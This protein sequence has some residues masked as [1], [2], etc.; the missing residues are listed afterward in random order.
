MNITDKLKSRLRQFASAEKAAFLP[1]FF[2]TAP[3]QYGHG[4]VFIGVMVPA[5]RQVAREFCD[6]AVDIQAL[7]DSPIHEERLVA[8]L[9]VMHRY[10]RAAKAGDMGEMRKWF[11]FYLRNTARINNWD[12]VDLSCRDVVGEHLH[13]KDRRLLRKLARSKSLWERRIAIVSTWAFI[14]RGEFDDTLAIAQMLLNDPHDLIHK[15]VGWMLREVGK[16]DQGVLE[17]FLDKTAA[18]MP[19]TMLR[20]AIERFTP[21]KKKRYMEMKATISSQEAAGKKRP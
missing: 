11:D 8:L 10:A 14:R 7:L 1:R 16:R 21:A 6:A 20:Y 18:V 13:G 12:L 15:A 4:D 9:L 17:G 5:S 2:K 19:R 3:G